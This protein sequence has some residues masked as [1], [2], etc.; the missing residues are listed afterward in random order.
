[1]YM[2]RDT[3]RRRWFRVL[4]E[5][6]QGS[7]IHLRLFGRQVAFLLLFGSPALF[8]DEHR[9]RLFLSMIRTMFGLS[10]LIVLGVAVF[11][12]RPLSPTSLC[13]WDH[14][15]A[16]MLLVLARSIAL[17]LLPSP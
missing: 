9:P 11:T 13:L 14:L 10:A 2:P 7:R 3:D 6:D 8:V 16:M 4:R 5:L 17:R 15:P 12:R 1:M